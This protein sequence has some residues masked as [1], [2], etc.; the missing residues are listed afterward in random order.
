MNRGEYI[1][2]TSGAAAADLR[3]QAARAFG[4]PH[5]WTSQLQRARENGS[6]L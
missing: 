5:Q 4:W 2:F 1:H 3:T 6:R